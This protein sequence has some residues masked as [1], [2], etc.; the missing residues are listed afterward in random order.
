MRGGR[1]PAL[2]PAVG[3][4]SIA[5]LLASCGFTPMYAE[6]AQGSPIRRIAVSTQDDRLGYRLREQLEDVLAWDRSAAPLYRLETSVEQSRRPLGR[7]IDDTATRYE[8]T[9]RAAWTLTPASGSGV[10]FAGVQTVTTT[11]ASADQPYAS[12]AAQ[13]DGED[14]AAAEL[15]RLIRL[16]LLRALAE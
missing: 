5:L 7:R 10:P 9:V 1:A 4:L 11:Y 12:I 15:A 8:L 16:D 2:T 14:R 13:Q 3:L 6:T